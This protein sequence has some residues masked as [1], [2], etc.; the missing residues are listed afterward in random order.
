MQKQLRVLG[1]AGAEFS[2]FE[3]ALPRYLAKAVTLL[4]PY[5]NSGTT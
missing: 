2:F 3:G 4:N 5:F 1:N